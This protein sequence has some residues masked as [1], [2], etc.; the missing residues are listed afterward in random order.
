[1]AELAIPTSPPPIPYPVRLDVDYSETQSRWKALFRIFLAI[2]VLLFLA[3]LS[4]GG[5]GAGEATRRGG[6]IAAG[7][8]SGVIVAIWVTIIVRQ[9][10]PRW[11]F[12]FQAWV[13]RWG[14]RAI[15]YTALLTD[16]YP[17]FEADYPIRYEIDY[18][19]RLSR[20]KVLVW[21]AITSVPHLIVLALL[22]LTLIVVVFIAWVAILITGKYPRGLH[23]YVVGVLRWSAR[24]QGYLYSLTDE[25]PPFSM[26][27]DAGA[28]ERDSYIIS[29][30]V[31]VIVIAAVT[32]GVVAAFVI[33]G[34][35][36]RVELTYQDLLSGQDIETQ[37]EVGNV[38]VTL[39]SA[40]DPLSEPL[41]D[42]LTAEPQHRLIEFDVIV[43]NHRR[44]SIKIDERD[45][46]LRDI[47]GHWHSP[48]LLLI[49]GRT[50]PV[51]IGRDDGS[52]M[53]LIFELKDGVDPD[54]LQ[55][56]VD[57]GRGFRTI[58]Y[59]FD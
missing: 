11:L 31:G 18:P 36:K 40:A 22:S 33:G 25:F 16:E 28:G 35:P 57:R 55:Y 32:A 49:S 47:D 10:I 59:D 17:A 2:P 51:K 9:R 12:D 39:P 27:A 3:L 7:G 21:K 46:R 29:A 30:V 8:T 6:E 5:G 43:E 41:A 45:F 14:L 24:V 58:E 1:V 42:L 52:A 15:G 23:T 4:G 38:A 13:N 48:F 56:K 19:D 50:V 26:R 34:Q 37:V 20:W 53:Q 54:K 44:H